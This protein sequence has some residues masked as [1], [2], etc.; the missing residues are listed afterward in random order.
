MNRLIVG[1]LIPTALQ[2]AYR[3][4]PD[5]FTAARIWSLKVG[6]SM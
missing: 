5:A 3:L 6:E 1:W 2:I 4:R